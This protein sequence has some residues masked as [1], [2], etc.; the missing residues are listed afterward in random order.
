MLLLL[1]LNNS[2]FGLTNRMSSPEWL[3]QLAL[4]NM[5]TWSW[6]WSEISRPFIRTTWSPSLSRG[7]QR[8]ACRVGS[9]TSGDNEGAGSDIS[10]LVSTCKAICSLF[11]HRA[12]SSSHSVV[13]LLTYWCS[14]SHSRHNDGHLLV[15]ST[16]ETNRFMRTYNQLTST[17]LRT[18]P[19]ISRN[20]G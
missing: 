19:Y 10:T 9:E 1:L 14:W 7:T 5:T 17:K 12:Y 18:L 3:S 16:L 4:M 2:P 20:R 11:I 15:S 13:R 8:S 6:V